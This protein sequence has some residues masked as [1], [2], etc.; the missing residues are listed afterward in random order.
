MNLSDISVVKKYALAYMGCKGESNEK[1]IDDLKKLIDICK[2]YSNVLRNPTIN[3]EVKHEILKKIVPQDL[4]KTVSFNLVALL[5]KQ[6]RF[7]LV[8]HIYQ[9]SYE[10]LLKS[11]NKIKVIVYSKNQLSENNQ[12][13]ILDF[14]KN[15]GFGDAV[16]E[17]HQKIDLIGGFVIR[18]DDIIIDA[19]INSK[20]EKLR[21]TIKEG[22]VL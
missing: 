5:V 10:I 11:K 15:A 7:S 21:K 14:F 22:V 19:T 2:N 1:K 17:W 12:K 13:M 4:I 16:I 3:Y 9:K 18:W 6:K 20:I 8:E